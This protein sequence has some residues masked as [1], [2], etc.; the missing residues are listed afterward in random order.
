MKFVNGIYTKI[1]NK[2]EEFKNDESG[3][4]T[5]E[6]IGIAAVIV[7]LVGVVSTAMSGASGIGEDVVN[8]IRDLISQ[9]GG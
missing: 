1:M 6:W 4:Q 5:L 2:V 9:I 8:K 7:I 3:S